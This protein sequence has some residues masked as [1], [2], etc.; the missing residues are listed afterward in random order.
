MNY[1][2]NFDIAAISIYIITIIYYFHTRHIKD[3]KNHLF[4]S[5]LMC[6]IIT[7]IAD[8]LGAIAIENSMSTFWVMAYNI[9]YY[10]SEQGTTFFFFAFVLAHLEIGFNIGAERKILMYFPIN[11]ITIAIITNPLHNYLFSYNNHVYQSGPLRVCCY[12]L[13]VYYFLWAAVYVTKRAKLIRK[14]FRVTVYVIT[15]I[16]LLTRA[17]QFYNK[18]LL[19]HTFSVSV[20][21]LLLLMYMQRYENVLDP[22]TGMGTKSY[23][24]DVSN[25]LFYNHIPFNIIMVRIAD[26]DLLISSYGIGNTEK[27]VLKIGDYLQ[28]FVPTGSAFQLNNSCFALIFTN[29]KEDADYEALCKEIYA[30]LG[31]IWDVD[32]IN[33]LCE[34]F[35]THVASVE[36]IPD[37]ESFIAYTTYFQ[38]MHRR[39]YGVVPADEL[40]VKDKLR[41]SLV[42]RAIERGIKRNNFEIYYQPICTTGDI[43]FVTAEALIRLRDSDLGMVPP[44]EFIPIAESNGTVVAIGNIVL[45]K[46]CEFIASNNM[47]ELGLEYIEINLSTIQCLQRDFIDVVKE[48]TERY[49]V[50][51]K[52]ICFEITETAANCSPAIFTENLQTLNDMGFSLALDDFGTGYANLQRLIT[53]PFNVVKFDKDMTQRTLDDEELH[54]LFEMMQ[55][56]FHT[57]GSKVVA[58]GVETLD[59]YNFLKEIGT[60]YIQGYFFSKP[61]PEDEFIKF[62]KAHK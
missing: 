60:D 1:N 34:S 12:L 11:A 32:G 43:K 57:M 28:G 5:L 46:V 24:D 55:N 49:N 35:V 17:I 45:D 14:E 13:P 62:L 3:L 47:S 25:K 31:Q 58:E 20:G 16:N 50:D 56:I 36:N 29:K 33:M 52:Y 23:L 42:E 7:P 38:K 21:I 4:V 59:Q 8:I 53:S 37:K 26:Y 54:T 48:I 6:S 22:N 2:Y 44:A 18:E 19:I 30:K 10:L 41:E 15:A 51:S 40:D 27:L 39:R 9:L 61:M